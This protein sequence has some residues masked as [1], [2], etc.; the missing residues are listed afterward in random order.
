[1]GF[2]EDLATRAL[3]EARR[4]LCLVEGVGESCVGC[5]KEPHEKES[6]R[7]T[8]KVLFGE[9]PYAAKSLHACGRG[10]NAKTCIK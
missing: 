7:K 3:P 10:I 9:D 1:M 6:S 5:R 4:E 2:H 8:L